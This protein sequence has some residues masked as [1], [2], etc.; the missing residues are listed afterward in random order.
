M[1]KKP[2]LRPSKDGANS[3]ERLL[4]AAVDVFGE[5]GFEAAT[6]R[7]IAKAAG[8]NIAA[9]PYYFSG[10]EGLYQAAVSH[11]V[12]IIESRLSPT[13]K[14][15][16]GKTEQG[17]LSP[18]EALGLLEKI[19]GNLINS[20]MGSAEGP[21]FARIILREHLFPSSAYDIIF[22]RVMG[23][24]MAAIATLIG[25]ASGESSPRTVKLRAAAVVG[26]VMAFRV[27]RETMVRALGMEGYSAEE[28]AE[29]RNVILQQTR[30]SM[31]L[32]MGQ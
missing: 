7:M 22:N 18:E 30:A 29:I 21:R 24:M 12:G 23:P 4:E 25:L 26:Q 16:E 20:M 11:I 27:A 31:N 1:L 14:E 8:V 3:Q 28:V 2:S 17:L 5:Q 32:K 13:L 6:T 9:I 19:L 10:K 15:I